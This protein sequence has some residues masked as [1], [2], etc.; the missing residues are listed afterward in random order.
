MRKTLKKAGIYFNMIKAMCDK[1]TAKI[2][3]TSKTRMPTLSLLL[4]IVLA[5]LAREIRQEK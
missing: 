2:I 3:L 5:G 1:P 4:N